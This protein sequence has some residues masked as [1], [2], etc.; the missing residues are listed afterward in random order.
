MNTR[1]PTL[2]I[3][4]AGRVG[5]T[6]AQT[7]RWRGYSVTAVYSRT[8]E[9][10][11]R[12]AEKL[13]TR[14]VESP[15]YAAMSA[16]LTFLTVP[17]DAIESV[18]E[19]LAEEAN[20]T[21]RAIVHTSGVSDVSVLRAA[22]ARGAWTGGLHPMLAIMDRDLSPNMAFSVPWV[23]QAPDVTF[24]V[25]A[26]AEPLISWLEAIVQALNGIALWL[27]PGQDRARYHAAGVIASNYVVTLFAEAIG[28]LE[29]LVGDSE[30]DERAIRQIVVH[31]MEA[32]L[33]NVKIAG[34]AQALTGPILRGD[35]GTI[36][37]HLDALEQVDPELAEMYRHLG[38]RTLKLAAQ[39]GT[40]A[41]KLQEIRERLEKNDADD[42]SKYSEDER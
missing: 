39:R 40:N 20:L 3:I 1:R 4:G 22:K 33:N 5:S 16:E 32:T 29:S 42:N 31:L 38:L 14:V 6:L 17:D 21:G 24:G 8:A 15:V 26:E 7:L 19:E 35:T 28:L 41:H 30:G 27:R 12:L 9:S 18:C 36:A 25:E 2:A 37:K 10:A 34:A 13:G 11:I 23:A